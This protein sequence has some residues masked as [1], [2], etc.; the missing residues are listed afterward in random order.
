MRNREKFPQKR[1]IQPEKIEEKEKYFEKIAEK[2][3]EVVIKSIKMESFD[4]SEEEI[5]DEEKI[6]EIKYENKKGEKIKGANQFFLSETKVK[7][8]KIEIKA[9]KGINRFD[10][11]D[12]GV[13]KG[14]IVVD[15]VINYGDVSGMKVR[16]KENEIRFLREINTIDL[17]GIRGEVK[18][19]KGKK[20]KIG[21]LTVKIDKGA[22]NG[23]FS[24]AKGLKILKVEGIMKEA[25]F[26]GINVDALDLTNFEAE[27]IN[28]SDAQYKEIRGNLEKF[29]KVEGV[30]RSE[31]G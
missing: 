1:E 26:S 21:E 24:G 29:N 5:E 14:K 25:D 4:F 8:G 17:S 6:I 27:T 19:V 16:G 15:S 31:E 30:E 3:A 22:I 13:E 9:E 11:S 12:I 18:K 7:N 10:G 2:T 28:L 23:D 20:E